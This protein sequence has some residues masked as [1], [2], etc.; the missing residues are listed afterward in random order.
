MFEQLVL[1][2]DIVSDPSGVDSGERSKAMRFRAGIQ[3]VQHRAIG[4]YRGIRNQ[5][6]VTAPRNCF[7]AH[8]HRGLQPGKSEKIF[9]GLIELA[10]LHVVGIGPETRIP[11]LSVAR[12][13]A[14]SPPTTKRRQVRVPQ[15]CIDERPL[16]ARSREVR[17]S[18]RCGE[19]ANID[20]MRR[21]FPCKQ[22]EKLLERSGRMPDREK[23][24][25]VHAP[26]S[27]L[28]LPSAIRTEV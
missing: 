12:I 21:A 11:P 26:R 4:S 5:E 25:G 10:R 15:A 7:G 6:A 14:P 2:S 17:V 28:P 18:R 8:D 1:R 16:E 9:E 22:P 19:G 3:Y 20:Q 23:L 13:A 27:C 24:S